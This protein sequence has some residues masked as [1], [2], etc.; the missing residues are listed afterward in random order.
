[1]LAASSFRVRSVDSSATLPARLARRVIR[2]PAPQPRRAAT[3]AQDG[4][5]RSPLARVPAADPSSSSLANLR[6]KRQRTSK[7][8][9]RQLPVHSRARHL[10]VADHRV[11]AGCNPPARGIRSGRRLVGIG[12]RGLPGE[13]MNVDVRLARP[14]LGRV[15]A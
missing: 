14:V 8:S 3:P 15:A 5:W 9:A 4:Q 2:D 1:M 12:P 10:R 11:V 13:Q 6:V 7:A